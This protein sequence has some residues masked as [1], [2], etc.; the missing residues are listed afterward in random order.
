MTKL[1]T[2]KVKLTNKIEKS[3]RDHFNSSK[4]YKLLTQHSA[5]VLQATLKRIDNGIIEFWSL[6]YLISLN[7]NTTTIV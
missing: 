7:G 2:S 5:S 3:V 6:L 1:K 4:P